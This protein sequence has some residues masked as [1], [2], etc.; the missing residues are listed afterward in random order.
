MIHKVRGIMLYAVSV[1]LAKVGNNGDACREVLPKLLLTRVP[2][3]D[4]RLVLENT[5]IENSSQLLQNL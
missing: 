4:S 2:E 5:A 1:Y 3:A